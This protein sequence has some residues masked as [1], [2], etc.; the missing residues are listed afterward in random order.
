MF[1]RQRGTS[2]ISDTIFL[3]QS[4]RPV[5]QGIIRNP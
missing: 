5:D 3:T 1:L 4:T 2:F